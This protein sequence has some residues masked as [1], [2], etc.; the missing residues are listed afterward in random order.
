[1]PTTGLQVDDAGVAT[2]LLVSTGSWEA[3]VLNNDFG[4]VDPAL[5]NFLFILATTTPKYT[6][7]NLNQ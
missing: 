7:L 3:D 2:W 1:M 5:V 6:E 4:F